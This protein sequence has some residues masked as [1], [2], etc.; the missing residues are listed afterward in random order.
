MRSAGMAYHGEQP[1]RRPNGKQML[2]ISVKNFGPI[3]E[4]SVDL[5]PLTIFVGPSNTGKSYMA[6]AVY[7]VMRAVEGR[8]Q[9]P[10]TRHLEQRGLARGAK[11][12][13][14]VPAK[15]TDAI[16]DWVRGQDGSQWVDQKIPFTA[17]PEQV[18][19]ELTGS[20]NQV[21]KWF[22]T[23]VMQQLRR[24]YR[25]ESEIVNRSSGPDYFGLTIERKSPFLKVEIGLRDLVSYCAEFDISAASVGA[26]HIEHWGTEQRLDEEIHPSVYSELVSLLRISA[27][28]CIFEGLPLSSYFLPASRTGIVQGQKIL[29]ASIIRQSSLLGAQRVN[30]PALPGVTT[31][32]L[33]D[34]VSL[35]KGLSFH[36]PNDDLD[37]AIRF[38]EQNVLRGEIDLDESA[39][40]PYPEISY[41]TAAGKFTVDHTSSMVTELAPLVLFLKYLVRP[42][43]LLI[44]EEPESHLHPAAQLQLARGIARLVN[45]G[46]QVLITTHSGDIMGQIDNLLRMSNSREDTARSLGLEQED[47]LS[48]EQVSAYGFRF[49]HDL[50]GAVTYPLPVGSDVGIEDDEFL[51]VAELLYHQ[52]LDLEDA[53]LT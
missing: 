49:D 14:E 35:D 39:G 40:L 26:Y 41:S 53:R 34:L 52:A 29:A 21:L 48:P 23:D 37:N 32:F 33:S 27:A 7:A 24:S 12:T 5:K 16:R 50:G 15:V 20:T 31:E 46:V 43:D 25:G 17:F 11:S 38:I 3:A 47:C 51:P 28:E 18:C 22:R 10:Y 8:P 9:V 4:G 42:G 6:T 36:R 45:A 19:A 44:L 1:N 30:I 2:T 13:W